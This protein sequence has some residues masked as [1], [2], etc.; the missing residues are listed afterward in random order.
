MNT[1][2]D[3]IFQ[4]GVIFYKLAEL[5]PASWEEPMNISNA[6]HLLSWTSALPVIC[7]PSVIYSTI[8]SMFKK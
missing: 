6:G 4:K 8:L 5:L 7:P 2:D 3:H 1:F